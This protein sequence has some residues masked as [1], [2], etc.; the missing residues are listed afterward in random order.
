MSKIADVRTKSDDE[1]NQIVTDLSKE[2]F[3]L[4]FQKTGGQ[5][6]NLARPRLVRKELAR[7]KTALRERALGLNYATAAKA[8]K[9]KKPAAKSAKK[10]AS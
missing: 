2:A 6:E 9:A 10:K 3:N 5:L 7:A 1:L 4:R 8:G